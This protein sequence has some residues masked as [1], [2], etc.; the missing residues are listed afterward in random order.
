MIV[1]FFSLGGDCPDETI[2]KGRVSG[3]NSYG[4]SITYTC[5]SGYGLVGGDVTRKCGLDGQWK[6][7]RPSCKGKITRKCGLDGPWKGKRPSC[8]GKITRN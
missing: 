6:G 1:K 3:G 7:K 2:S 5:N 8:K 4:D